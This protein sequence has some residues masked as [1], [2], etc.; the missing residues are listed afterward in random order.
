MTIEMPETYNIRGEIDDD[1]RC[2]VVDIDTTES[3]FVTGYDVH[4]GNAQRVHHVIVWNPTEQ[5][6]VDDAIALD[7]A[8]GT[9]GDGYEVLRWTHGP[10]RRRSCSGRRGRGRPRS[11]A[12]P[13]SRSKRGVRRS[14]RSTTTTW[15]PTARTRTGTTIDLMVEDSANPA[16]FVPLA[17]FNLN[18]APRMESITQSYRQSLDL[19]PV[20]VRVWGV[21]PH[22]HQ[23]GRQLQV[24]IESGGSEDQCLIDIPRWDFNWQLAYWLQRPVRVDPTDSAVISCTYNTLERDET[25]FWGDGTQDEMCLAFV[26]VTI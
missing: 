25:V 7:A 1:Y 11:P 3:V 20:P 17:N 8:D 12:G 6:E 18:L 4:P 5:G 22:M 14:F 23:L 13:G 26:Y 16:F 9:M 21:F 10:T 15:S 2:F 19:L 24:E